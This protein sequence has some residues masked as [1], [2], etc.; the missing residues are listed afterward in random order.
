[1]RFEHVLAGAEG[2]RTF[3][4]PSFRFA[5]A[6]LVASALCFLALLAVIFLSSGV[7]NAQGPGQTSDSISNHP[8]AVSLGVAV[9]ALNTGAVLTVIAA[10]NRT[11]GLAS[12]ELSTRRLHLRKPPLTIA[13]KLDSA[14]A[15]QDALVTTVGHLVVNAG[16]L[17]EKVRPA[18]TE[19]VEAERKTHDS[20]RA[21]DGTL[22]QILS[23]LR[24]I[25]LRLPPSAP[26]AAG[27][28][29]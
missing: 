2:E 12:H 27:G 5:Y 22:V 17:V 11:W 6:L 18:M 3:R 15:A 1:M 25:R 28:R 21:V 7:A 19:Y 24:D 16:N 20:L 29:A 9:L 10:V 4:M 13:E 26:V 8:L 23:E 14:R